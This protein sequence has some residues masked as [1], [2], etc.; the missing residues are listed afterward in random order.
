M[1]SETKTSS[2]RGSASSAP[3]CIHHWVI[4]SADGAESQGSCKHCGAKRGFANSLESEGWG[5]IREDRAG[6]SSTNSLA[7]IVRAK[8]ERT[9]D[10]ADEI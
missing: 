1:A 3:L 4:D 8:P 5:A 2:P 10:L 6:S 9:A 7:S